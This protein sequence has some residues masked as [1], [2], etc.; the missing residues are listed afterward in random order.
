[1]YF[2]RYIPYQTQFLKVIA[3]MTSLLCMGLTRQSNTDLPW[4]VALPNRMGC[5]FRLLHS[6]LRMWKLFFNVMSVLSGGWSTPKSALK[7]AVYWVG[8]A[9]QSELS[10]SPCTQTLDFAGEGWKNT[11]RESWKMTYLKTAHSLYVQQRMH[12]Q[13]LHTF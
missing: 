12:C 2:N 7:V 3:I 1:M 8:V 9:S 5:P 4:Q 6:T 10:T 11:Q 13:S